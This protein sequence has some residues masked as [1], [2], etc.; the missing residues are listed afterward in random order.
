L[1][2]AF[3]FFFT[4]HARLFLILFD[5]RLIKSPP[6]QRTILSFPLV[7]GAAMIKKLN[8]RQF[9]SRSSNESESKRTELLPVR[10][11]KV[12]ASEPKQKNA[13]TGRNMMSKKETR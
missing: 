3:S 2:R 4:F 12:M 5:V 6:A 13:E 11:G 7:F 9:A 1:Q 8:Y 10:K